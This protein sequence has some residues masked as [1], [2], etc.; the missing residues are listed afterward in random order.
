[1]GPGYYPVDNLLSRLRYELQFRDSNSIFRRSICNASRSLSLLWV[2]VFSLFQDLRRA[3]RFSFASKQALDKLAHIALG[4]RL[5]ANEFEFKRQ[6]TKS[7][8]RWT[9]W[10]GG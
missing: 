7:A 5:R 8:G 10:N 4:N 3:R 1:M 9:A 2:Y 6:L